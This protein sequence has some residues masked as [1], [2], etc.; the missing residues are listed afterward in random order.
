[1]NVLPY[2]YDFVS[3]LFEDPEASESIKG[4]ILFGSVARGDFDKKSD[5]DLFIDTSAND[6]EKV[7]LILREAEKR[8]VVAS[9][10]KW[11]TMGI[12]LPL[13]TIVGTLE[14]PEWKELR[15]EISSQGITIYGKNGLVP[16]NVKRLSLLSYSLAKISQ[17]RKMN[18]LRRLFGYTIRKSGKEYVQEG[19]IE[20]IGGEK[21]GKNAV[22][23]PAEK[24]REMRKLFH[25]FGVNPRI[26]EVWK[27]DMHFNRGGNG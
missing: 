7:T 11:E 22:I 10:K 20:K 19:L 21:V 26:T 12:K 24:T 25:S 16:E 9:R 27:R 6:V 4:V 15:G 8:F 18:L 2:L 14:G 23:V 3:L 17:E 5:I 1:M 13:N